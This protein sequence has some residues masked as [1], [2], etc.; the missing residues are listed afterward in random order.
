MEK[1]QS[2]METQK[3]YTPS[4]E[5][6]HVGFEFEHEIFE[7]PDNNSNDP[8]GKW[9]N[10]STIKCIGDCSSRTIAPITELAVVEAIMTT[11]VRDVVR[12]KY[13]DKDD[14]ESLGWK[15]I[16]LTDEI[17]GCISCYEIET[18]DQYFLLGLYKDGKVR[19]SSGMNT[20]RFLFCHLPIKNKS[21]LKKLMS[22]INIIKL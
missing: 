2:N 11:Y 14:I 12:V 7:M 16:T 5:E 9:W 6:F 18:T 21:E 17:Y 1:M 4:I 20:P 13:L 8:N 22:Q 15:P 10:K 19:I 3:Y